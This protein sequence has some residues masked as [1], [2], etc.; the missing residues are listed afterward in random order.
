MSCFALMHSFFIIGDLQ[1]HE[2]A[3]EGVPRLQG[4]H[5]RARG[6]GPGGGRH[7]H[8]EADGHRWVRG[9]GASNTLA[10]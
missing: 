2:V 10:S 8:Q 4:D 6:R 7:Q 9:P 1:T 3:S 5:L